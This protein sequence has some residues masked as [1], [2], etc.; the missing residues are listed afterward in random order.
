MARGS[1][2]KITILGD[3]KN[4]ERAFKRAGAAG[5]GMGRNFARM[6]K[7]AAIGTAAV[8]AG[9][10]VLGKKFV[11]AAL[12]AEKA[13][14]RLD[15]AFKSANVTARQRAAAMDA[16]SK[17]SARAGLDD[18]ELMD[19]LGRLTRVT[20]S[21]AKAQQEM[22]IAADI[23]RARNVSLEAAT[24][25]VSKAH[26]GQLGALK[27]IGIE[28]PKVTTAQDALRASGEKVSAEAMKAAKAQDELATRQA[29]VA[30]L[31]RQYAGASEEYGRS[32]SGAVDR[33]KVAWE[34]LQ[35]TLGAKLLP[36]VGR[37][38]EWFLR[39]MPT[40]ERVV[41]KTMSAIGVVIEALSPVFSRL[42]AGISMV[43]SAAERYWPQ[44]Q[45]AAAKVV[46]WY[47][48]TLAPAIE[49]VLT[50]IRK[51]WEIFGPAITRVATAAFNQIKTVVTTAMKIIGGTVEA[52]LALIRGDWSEA[53]NK[54][55]QVAKAAL[56]GVV[57]TIRNIGGL[58]RDAAFAVGQAIVQGIAAGLDSLK[59]WLVG[60]AKAIADA[61]VG[62]FK[63]ALHIG[64]P[65]RVTADEIG[66]PFVQG[67]VRG[68][69]AETP[70]LLRVAM[71]TS[72]DAAQA[73]RQGILDAKADYGSAW[74]GY[75]SAALAAFDDMSSKIQTKSERL[76][77][78]MRATREKQAIKQGV[79]DARSGLAEARAGGDPDAILAAERALD[80]ALYRQRE[81]ALEQKAAL[82][83]RKQDEETAS[84]RLR[85]EKWLAT[86]S[87][88]QQ[89]MLLKEGAGQKAIVAKIKSYDEDYKAAGVRL[90]NAL[91]QGLLDARGG[92]VDAANKLAAAVNRA[93]GVAASA[94]KSA[95]DTT[96][97]TLRG[98]TEGRAVGGPV[99]RGV[100][101][102]V[103]E[104]G[105]EVFVPSTSGR[106]I[107]NGGMPGG[108]G[109]RP[110]G[111]TVIHV[112]LPNYLGSPTEVAQ[113]IRQELIKIGR[114]N[115]G[116]LFAGVA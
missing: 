62:A 69:E 32:T 72:K 55:K 104:D 102:V 107:P 53:W 64:S 85:F 58:A 83:R 78:K 92:V 94:G 57:A 75:T 27:R 30:A 87:I 86:R 24:Q 45:Q 71:K 70:N 84:D 14:V 59:D 21:A 108:S 43:A 39:N 1:E 114:N 65:S 26:L 63:G 41:S 93:L 60:K 28:I 31:Q 10:V 67:I 50:A 76:L 91:A 61:V 9:A 7:L 79:S 48:G 66:R 38:S 2:I 16:V 13:Q 68:M 44:V 95:A 29:A 77:D 34:N 100:P 111:G 73:A 74:G 88:Q 37:V 19:T 101:Y 11:S 22:A 42:I 12:D 46:A 89:S 49:N 112:S 5:E 115:A 90:G 17:V 96:T 82:E 54:L 52:V 33:A 81:Y 97:G 98:K 25:I 15:A 8:G 99:T 80:D 4:A 18:E 110:V 20:G 109:G 36:V 106:V 51:A 116:N 23:A 40:I 3:S 6:G 103:G 113:V 35:E 47:R 105:P 56:D